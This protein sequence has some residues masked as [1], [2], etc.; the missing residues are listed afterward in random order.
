M[1]MMMMMKVMVMMMST[2]IAHDSVNLNAQCAE[3]EW[4]KTEK[5]III[6]IKKKTHG[7]KSFTEQ[8]GFSRSPERRQRVC[9]PDCLW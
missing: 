9:L 8:M 4:R 5:V 2:F 1:M 3:G 6:Q 7:A